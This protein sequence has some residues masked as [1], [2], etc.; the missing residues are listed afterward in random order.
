MNTGSL[1]H[2]TNS[3]SLYFFS[4]M[5]ALISA[6]HFQLLRPDQTLTI[7]VTG[8]QVNFPFSSL[9]LNLSPVGRSLI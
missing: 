3:K 9:N 6:L 8:V 1:E 7:Y 4:A 5:F 2:N